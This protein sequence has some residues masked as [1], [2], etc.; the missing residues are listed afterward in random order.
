MKN[1]VKPRSQASAASKR[2]GRNGGTLQTGNPGNAGGGRIPSEVRQLALEKF[3]NRLERL[4]QIAGGEA[5]LAR[6][7]N[8]KKKLP[9]TVR[10]QRAAIVDL[11]KLGGMAIRIEHDGLP[12]APLVV[13]V[14]TGPAAAAE[15]N[16]PPA[17]Q[18]G[19]A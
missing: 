5:V 19:A 10:E 2:P 1:T 8:G 12:A 14:L 18:P 15:L 4:D 6:V 16:L 7:G 13:G 17:E 3:A 9:A 11:A